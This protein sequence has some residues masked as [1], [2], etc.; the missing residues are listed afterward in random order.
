MAGYVPEY[1]HII[2][3]D[4]EPTKEL[5]VGKYRLNTLESSGRW[6]ELR[7][8]R[9]NLSHM[10]EDELEEMSIAINDIFYKKEAIEKYIS[11]DCLQQPENNPL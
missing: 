4:F 9:N 10:Y 5:S 8:I 7:K 2:W 3:L 6:L 1:N 11:I